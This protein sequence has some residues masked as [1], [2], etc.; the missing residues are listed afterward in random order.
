MKAILLIF[1]TFAGG[2][3][4]GG[5]SIAV[6]REEF[7][8]AAICEQAA[9]KVRRARSE[10]ANGYGNKMGVMRVEAVCVYTE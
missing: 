6:H 5:A 2:G 9:L 7:T 10:W 8:S 4:D 1:A 3:G